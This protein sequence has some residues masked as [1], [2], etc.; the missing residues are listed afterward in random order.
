MIE[1]DIPCEDVWAQLNATKST[2]HKCGQ[3]VLEGHIRH[4]IRHEIEKDDVDET[5]ESFT[6]AV[7][8]FANMK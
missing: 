8:W 6:K 1:E 2:L 4:C 7:E 5:I 3:I